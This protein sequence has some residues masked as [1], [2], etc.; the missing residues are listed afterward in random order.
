MARAGML[1]F[2]GNADLRESEEDLTKRK[3]TVGWARGTKTKDTSDL[4]GLNT[5]QEAFEAG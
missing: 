1:P 5:D 3:P 4:E 2:Y